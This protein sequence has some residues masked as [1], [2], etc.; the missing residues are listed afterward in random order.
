M[1]IISNQ[2]L[3]PVLLSRMH[4]ADSVVQSDGLYTE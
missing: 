4:S 2:Y 3:L 1:T